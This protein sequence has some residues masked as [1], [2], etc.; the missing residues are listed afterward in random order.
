MKQ[1]RAWQA[2]IDVSGG[3]GPL[4]RITAQPKRRARQSM[5]TVLVV[6]NHSS[7]TVSVQRCSVAA[8][9]EPIDPHSP[10]RHTAHDETLATTVRATQPR[11]HSA[12][13]ARAA[14]CKSTL[15]LHGTTQHSA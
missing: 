12:L 6:S 7:L 10:R 9:K 4:T 2:C 11:S 14:I 1:G 15:V 3:S 13:F 5:L 8:T